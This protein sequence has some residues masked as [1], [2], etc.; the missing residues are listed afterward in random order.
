MPTGT[1]M[2]SVVEKEEKI[3]REGKEESYYSSRW[4]G[5]DKE[6]LARLKV[7]K[8]YRPILSAFFIWFWI[9]VIVK[10]F[11]HVPGLVYFYPIVVFLIAGR[12]GALLQLAHD[13]AH[14]LISKGKFN[15]WFG[16]WIACYP[17]GLDLKGYGEPHLRHHACTNKICDPLS[18]AEK[19]KVCD[20]RTPRLWFLFLKDILGITAVTI[21]LRYDQPL[22]NRDKKDIEDYVEHEEGS[23]AYRVSPGSL[24]QTLKKYL[25]IALVQLLILGILFRFNIFHYILLWLVPL[26]TAHMFLMRIRG[27]GEHG[28]GIQLGISELDQKNRGTFYTRS[29]GTPL[30]RYPFPLLNLL[31]RWLIGSLNVYYHH[32]HHL[33]PKVPYYN[34]PKIHKIISRKTET[35]NPYVFAR[36]YFDCLFFNLRHPSFPSK[37]HNS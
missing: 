26:V 30:K 17:I 12:A 35:Y 32:E 19:Y 36:G 16:N 13:A 7:L 15:D 5:I 1:D 29:F 34:L 28:L 10:T 31:E 9:T 22:T 33:Y 3:E 2:E 21:Q 23:I 27:I 18:D 6:T 24:F 11:L 20:I 4:Y 25:S 14:G 8:P 37:S